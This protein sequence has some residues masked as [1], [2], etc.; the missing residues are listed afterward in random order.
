LVT[1]LSQLSKLGLWGTSRGNAHLEA[2]TKETVYIIGGSAFG[3]L[4]GH[5]LL[6]FKALSEII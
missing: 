1:F 3:E 2:T 5:K 4:E 6:V